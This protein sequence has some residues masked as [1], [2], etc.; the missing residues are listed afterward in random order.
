M[1]ERV[2]ASFISSVMA[3]MTMTVSLYGWSWGEGIHLTSITCSMYFLLFFSISFPLLLL[4]GP[5]MI[6]LAKE[7]SDES[8]NTRKTTGHHLNLAAY[9]IYGVIF[10]LFIWSSIVAL[11]WIGWITLEISKDY[12]FVVTFG[13]VET[14]F[15]FYFV[16]VLAVQL[17]RFAHDTSSSVYRMDRE[18]KEQ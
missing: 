18:A 6:N 15:M 4:F 8:E 9:L 5:A 3:S 16:A 10:V 14:T 12:L 7:K 1:F 13:M 2:M 17:L 11:D